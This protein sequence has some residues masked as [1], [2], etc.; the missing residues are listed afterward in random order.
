MP[1]G[2][3]QRVKLRPLAER[4]MERVQPEPNSG[5][6]LWTGG[7]AGNG[8]GYLSL[9]RRSEGMEY[10]HRVSYRIHVGMI[11]NHKM[12]LHK[13]DVPNCVNPDHLF[14]GT[15]FDNMQDCSKKERHGSQK[16]RENA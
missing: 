11:P 14:L 16:R 8:Y 4:F 15:Q 13:C 6:W 1:K 5:C 10:A 2:I 9:G 12:V 7:V 3:Y